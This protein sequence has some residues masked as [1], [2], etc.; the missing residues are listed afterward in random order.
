MGLLSA[1][2]AI[3]EASGSKDAASRLPRANFSPDGGMLKEAETSSNFGSKEEE[4]KEESFTDFIIEESEARDETLES[5][6]GGGVSVPLSKRAAA[7][8]RKKIKKQERLL[9]KKQK[10]EA[11]KQ[12]K[13]KLKLRHSIASNLIVIILVLLFASIGAI[14]MMVSILVSRD[15]GLTAEENNFTINRRNSHSISLTLTDVRSAT[16]IFFYNTKK[17]IDVD[18]FFEEKK[19]LISICVF[20]KL[21]YS[22]PEIFTNASFFLINNIDEEAVNVYLDVIKDYLERINAGETVI[23]NASPFF[24]VPVINMSFLLPNGKPVSVLFS[25]SSMLRNFENGDNLSFL[26]NYDGDVLI[27]PDVSLVMGG[28]NLRRIPYILALMEGEASSDNMQKHYVDE[29]GSEYIAAHRKIDLA[30]PI[31][32]GGAHL[33]TV[34]SV[35][36]V[37]HG[38]FY[39]IR[40]NITVGFGVLLISILIIFI[41]SHSISGPLNALVKASSL[42][43][44]GN[45]ALNL[46]VKTYDELGDLTKNFISMANSIED[47]ERFTNRSLVKLARSGKM[48]RTGTTKTVTIGFIFIRDFPE[49]TKGLNAKTIVDFINDFFERTVPCITKTG[50]IVDKFLTQGGV[51]IMAVWGIGENTVSSEEDAYNCIRSCLMMRMALCELNAER[52]EKFWGRSPLIKIGCGI[53]SGEVV[54]GQI[55]SEDRMEYTVIGD[56]VNLAARLEG[57]NDLFD[58]DILISE[59][60]KNMLTKYDVLLEEMQSLKV[61]GK[62]EPLRVFSV[63]NLADTNDIAFLNEEYKSAQKDETAEDEL[64]INIK[65]LRFKPISLVS[66]MHQMRKT[67]EQNGERLYIETIDGAA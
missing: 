66:T 43:E 58:T 11:K 6:S 46:R 31:D 20:S 32:V 54:A 21:E 44:D 53:N 28:A 3:L 39:T 8:K 23:L 65:E 13:K 10:K 2:S 41:F 63:I 19:D 17:N 56:V 1:S 4:K 25:T 45:Y 60:T 5:D 52:H 49:M 48:V 22:E 57:P 18:A 29:S 14:T 27:H 61:Q 7:K 12:L 37:F 64:K 26:V 51:I 36:S 33:I 50:G 42:I 40:Q 47:F 55:G 38:I 16:R 15:V 62:K 34:I 35:D 24:G 59:N 9:A 67:F 30:S